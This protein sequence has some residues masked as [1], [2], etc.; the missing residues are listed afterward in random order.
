MY[1]VIEVD[2]HWKNPNM[3]RFW[4][5]IYYIYIFLGGIEFWSAHV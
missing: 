1:K 3:K 5:C 2:A 4:A